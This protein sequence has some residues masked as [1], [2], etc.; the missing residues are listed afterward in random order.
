MLINSKLY[1]KSCRYQYILICCGS[2]CS[3]KKLKIWRFHMIAV[4][5]ENVNSLLSLLCWERLENI[6]RVWDAHELHFM[7][8]TT[9]ILLCSYFGCR[10]GFHNVSSVQASL[11][12]KPHLVAMNIKEFP[13]SFLPSPLLNS[14]TYLSRPIFDVY[15]YFQE[16]KWRNHI[17]CRYR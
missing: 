10:H 7:P 4:F 1:S 2:F 9:L 12:F 17:H 11:T 16:N 14:R 5:R 13:L 3:H 8:I 15:F 6:Q